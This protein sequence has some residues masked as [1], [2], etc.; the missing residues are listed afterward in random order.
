MV[1]FQPRWVFEDLLGTK[2]IAQ[3]SIKAVRVRLESYDMISA[4]LCLG[5]Y[6]DPNNREWR[7]YFLADTNADTICP[8]NSLAENGERLT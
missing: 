7:Q 5:L 1:T 4:A 2:T 3:K 6:G 8:F